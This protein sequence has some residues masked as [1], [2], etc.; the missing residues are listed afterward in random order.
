MPEM[1]DLISRKWFDLKLAVKNLFR[2]QYKPGKYL[3]K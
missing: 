3:H 2:K 1:K